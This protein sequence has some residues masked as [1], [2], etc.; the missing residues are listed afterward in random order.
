MDM[1]GEKTKH[2]LIVH[3]LHNV[4]SLLV[5]SYGLMATFT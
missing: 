1:D 3:T 5:N 2:N 4:K